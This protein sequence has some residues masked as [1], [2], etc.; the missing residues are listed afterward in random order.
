MNVPAVALSVL[1][2]ALMGPT[3]AA[4]RGLILDLD[5]DR[6]VEVEDGDRVV[7]WTSQVSAF[8]PRE[9]VKRDKGRKVPGSGRPTLKKSVPAVGGHNTV[10]FRRQEL[11]NHDEDAFDSLI[12]GGGYTWFAVIAA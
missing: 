10:V 7:K 1:L 12:T 6:G 9:F 5:A 3:Q 4:E 8:P 11:I 2:A